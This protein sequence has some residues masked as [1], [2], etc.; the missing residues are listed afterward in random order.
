M[1]EIACKSFDMGEVVKCALNL[2]RSELSIMN[3]FLKNAHDRET[4]DSIS[5]KLDLDLSTVQRAVKHLHEKEILIK[6]QNNLDGG[7]YV[8]IYK[9]NEKNKIKKLIMDSVNKWVTRVEN[10]IEKL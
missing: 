9:L 6:S 1:V 10:E 4:T 8:F 2:T 7:G 3:Y 5:K